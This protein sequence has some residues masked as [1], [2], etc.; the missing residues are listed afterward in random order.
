[1]LIA[2]PKAFQ[3]LPQG[4]GVIR[5]SGCDTPFSQVLLRVFVETPTTKHAPEIPQ[6]CGVVDGIDLLA[7]GHRPAESHLAFLESTEPAE[8]PTDQIEGQILMMGRASALEEIA[9]FA[10]GNQ[11]FLELLLKE[12]N[13]GNVQSSFRYTPNPAE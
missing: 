3:R 11:G 10:P 12:Q 5:F 8:E 6:A 4:S 13:M 1:M 7:E 9:G 2:L